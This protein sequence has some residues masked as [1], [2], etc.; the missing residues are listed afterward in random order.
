[1]ATDV[2]SPARRS[3]DG[4]AQRTPSRAL[5]VVLPVAVWGLLVAVGHTM[6]RLLP[7]SAR[8]I[9]IDAAP[10]VGRVDWRPNARVL[11]AATVAVAIAAAGPGHAMR[12]PWRRLLLASAVAAFVW[13]LA[14][15]ALDGGHALLRPVL[16]SDDYLAAV[17]Q[18]GSP[19]AFLATFPERIASYPV[20]V[21]G[22]P[23]G[24][25][26]GL[27]GLDRIGLGGGAATAAL[28]IGSGAAAIP[29]VLV[30]ARD[31]AGEAWA[32]RAAP[33]V[34]L[35]PA[36][37][38]VATS[39]DALYAGVGAWAVTL[40]VLATGRRGRTGDRL[41]VGGGLLF[42]V[43]AF[44]SYGLVLLAVIPMVVAWQRC[45]LRPLVGAALGAAAV[46]AAFLAAGFWWVD[47]LAATRE[48]YLGGIAGERPYAVF[49]VANLAGLAIALGPA[50]AVA[51]AR[52]RDRSAWLLVGAALAAVALAD[53]SGMSKGEVE[54]IWL[55]FVPWILLACGALAGATLVRA[56]VTRRWLVVQATAAI[57]LQTMVH[58]P[59]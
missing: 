57:G 16:S 26:L 28:F 48:R 35:T 40:V 56:S 9:H 34:V 6:V 54:R 24:L 50:I 53:L 39:A 55:P 46:A 3:I 47:G 49:L 44:L 31:V 18:V 8:G 11:L 15:A 13:A 7:V 27:W 21:Q 33:F 29:A 43:T 22:H 51:L 12:V 30:A 42:G 41:A 58:T 38:W 14:L 37:L 45:R 1:M 5:A 20:H 25:V 4:A 17:A 10:L 52:L 19:A 59:W 23:P 36:A 2:G 32:R